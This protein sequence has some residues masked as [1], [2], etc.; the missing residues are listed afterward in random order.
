MEQTEK[1]VPFTVKWGCALDV[2][3]NIRVHW[4]Y[5]KEGGK[6]FYKFPSFLVGAYKH[7]IEQYIYFRDGGF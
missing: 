6:P 4:H 5:F 2:I 7:L 3:K 1:K